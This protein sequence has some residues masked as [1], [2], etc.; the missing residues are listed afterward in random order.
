MSVDAE[1][2]ELYRWDTVE[3]RREPEDNSW[4][5]RLK[6]FPSAF[7]CGDT[8]E[9]AFAEM[10]SATTSVLDAL[11]TWLAEAESKL[12]AATTGGQE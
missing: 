5:V 3:M 10:L 9:E 1:R 11:S 2:W 4:V 7:G 8:R 12:R 6:G